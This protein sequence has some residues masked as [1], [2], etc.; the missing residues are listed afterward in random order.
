MQINLLKK[1]VN[2]DVEL[3]HISEPKA[4]RTDYIIIISEPSLL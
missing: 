3:S 1:C 4:L 2:S